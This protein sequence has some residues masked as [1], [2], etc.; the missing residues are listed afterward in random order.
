MGPDAPQESSA[1]RR[2]QSG[3][4]GQGGDRVPY[5]RPEMA[6]YEAMNRVKTTKGLAKKAAELGS[7]LVPV[8]EGEA[9]VT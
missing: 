9:Q 5:V 4:W 2:G 6:A 7:K 1:V 3:G 8:G